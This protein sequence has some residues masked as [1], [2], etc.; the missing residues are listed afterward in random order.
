MV[1][2][3]TLGNF[4][5]SNGKTVLGGV[6]GSGLDTEA[7][8]EGLTEARSLAKVELEDKVALNGEKSTALSQLKSLLGR[9]KDA[10]N[11]LRNPPGVSNA[12]D[13]VF[14]ATSANL[15]SN[16]AVAAS[17]YLSVTTSAGATHQS[18]SIT[19]IT[20]VAKATQ[21]ATGN[22]SVAD[23]DG[24]VVFSTAAANQ[25]QAGTVTINDTEITLSD[26]DTLSGVA[27]KFNAVSSSTG[28]NATVIQVADGTY[29]LFFSATQTGEDSAFDLNDIY[30][31]IGNPTGTIIDPD[32]VFS[33]FTFADKQTA[34]NAEFILNGTTITRQSNVV[35]DVITGVTFNLLQATP[36]DTTLGI[37]VVPDN[38]LVKSGI[39]NFANVYNELRIFAA[40]QS[41]VG[42]DGLYKDTAVLNN[43]QTMRSI[44]DSLGTQVSSIV[45]GITGGDPTRLADIGI[46]LTDLPATADAPEAKNIITIDEGKLTNAIASNFD[47][48][49]RIFE[50][51]LQSTNPNL[52]VFSRTNALDV[53]EFTLNLNPF[54]TQTTQTISVADADTDVVTAVEGDG[55]FKAG[56]LTIRGQDIT[57]GL[58]DSLND[59]LAAFQAVEGDT[60]L[61]ASLEEVSAGN[62][63]FV[64]TSTVDAGSVNFD[65]E[66]TLV[67]PDGVFDEV[68]VTA[69]GAYT[70]TYTDDDGEQ[71][72]DVDVTLL[73]SGTNYRIEGQKG[74][75]LEGLVLLY[76]STY[77]SSIDVTAT[78]GIA[79]KV[80]NVSYAN[81]LD[82]TGSIAIELDALSDSDDKL[83][84]DIARIEDQIVVFRN[85]L[86]EKFSRLESALSQV[87]TL[88]QSLQADADARNNS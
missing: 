73:S 32:G 82:D 49:R 24:Q 50:F 51:D 34:S 12:A 81:A 14:K 27:A 63:R 11:F 4:F 52:R 22:I 43:N 18:Y 30:D 41:E 65:L 3:I 28:I 64:F 35:N 21:Q 54:A 29:Q 84:E 45:A 15:I 56:T 55:L 80:Y 44:L 62:Y 85:Q 46:T 72:I 38:D 2:A 25:F 66:S 16:T 57:F 86:I 83:A 19:E 76:S 53:S 58:G 79:D 26:G 23:A 13:N 47:G 39:I 40:E 9:L 7:L 48:V 8:I 1:T 68:D 60:G 78:Q 31:E 70:A 20:S 17:N 59:I 33:Q 74:T 71:T 61:V 42:A 75:V 67:D 36:E 77:A 88:L 69:T 87:N 5:T 10:A 6:G 37:N